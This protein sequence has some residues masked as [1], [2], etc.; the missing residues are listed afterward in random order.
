[1]SA[2]RSASHIEFSVTDSGEGIDPHFLPHVF[3][4][5][6]QA[7]NPRSRVHG[8]LGLGLSIVRYLVEA[9]GGSVSAESAGR[10]RGSKFSVW[11]PIAAIKLPSPVGRETE[12][13]LSEGTIDPARLKGVRILMV[14]DDRETRA[15]VRALLR[16]AGAEVTVA[17]SAQ[18]ALSEL[19]AQTP[20]LLITD[21]AMP[22]TDGFELTKIIRKRQGGAALKIIALSAFPA[23]GTATDA[24]GFD[25]YLRKPIDPVDLIDAVAKI[26]GR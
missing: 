13:G 10:G 20:D 21:I 17:D 24:G 9:H 26:S 19:D 12:A 23:A 11:L 1:L 22:G 5:F 7:E 25:L 4:P 15:L 16:Q 2:R 8:G 18:G 14:D 3:E 6:V